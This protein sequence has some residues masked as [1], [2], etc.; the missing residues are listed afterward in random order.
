MSGPGKRRSPI[1]LEPLLGLT[2]V[3]E[4]LRKH[5][6]FLNKLLRRQA[7]SECEE[8]VLSPS[9]QSCKVKNIML[10][11]L[12]RRTEQRTWARRRR[13]TGGRNI[14]V[15][16]HRPNISEEPKVAVINLTCSARP[17]AHQEDRGWGHIV[18][19]RLARRPNPSEP[20]SELAITPLRRP[21]LDRSPSLSPQSSLTPSHWTHASFS[22]P[23]RRTIF[24]HKVEAG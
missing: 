20:I 17:Q 18:R 4:V 22:L 11:D 13:V 14:P 6:V 23:H 3:P 8:A 21:V 15:L 2:P 16:R 1:L 12:P 5:T 10:G 9:T 19:T 24:S 7:D